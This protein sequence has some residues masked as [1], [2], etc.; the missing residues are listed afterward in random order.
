[1]TDRAKKAYQEVQTLIAD[2]AIPMNL[3]EY[4]EYLK[5]IES[6]VEALIEGAK[7]DKVQEPE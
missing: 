7:D 2:R 3:D 4:I 5:E 6:H 1:M